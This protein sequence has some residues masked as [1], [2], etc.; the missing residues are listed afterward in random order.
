[1][2]RKSI[3]S[4]L[5]ILFCIQQGTL[6]QQK[7]KYR[8]VEYKHDQKEMQINM[9]LYLRDYFVNLG[10][11]LTLTPIIKSD[12]KT[13]SLPNIIIVGNNY[14]FYWSNNIGV[15][16]KGKNSPTHMS[17]NVNVPYEAWME[18]SQLIVKTDLNRIGGSELYSNIEKL[19]D[20]PTSGYDNFKHVSTPPAQTYNITSTESEDKSIRAVIYSLRYPYKKA[21]MISQS[22]ELNS[23]NDEMDRIMHDDNIVL[24]RIDIN[25]TTSIDG[26]YL[27]NDELTLKQANAFKNYLQKSYNIPE[28]YFRIKGAS[29]DW[30]GLARQVEDSD[31]P[32]KQD[33]LN[34][35]S[36]YGIFNGR[37]RE[38]MLLKSGEPYVYMKNHMFPQSQQVECRI[39]YK[40][41]K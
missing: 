13:I 41:R 20:R 31:M 39:L 33:V 32:Y 38:L 24:I 29:E 5:I 4:L 8:D 6:A 25:V 26:V 37:E 10:D 18:N 30:D 7:N 22:Q 14:A 40:E 3:L 34:V 27:D 21:M 17:Y 19:K 16:L 35:M 15:F 23:L 36:K 1:M 11:S 12:K 28:A 9:S 2:E